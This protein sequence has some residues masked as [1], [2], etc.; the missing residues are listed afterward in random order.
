MFSSARSYLQPPLGSKCSPQ[1]V[2]IFSLLLDPNVLLSTLISYTFNLCSSLNALSAVLVIYLSL[3]PSPSLISYLLLFHLI[4]LSFRLQRS[5]ES[6]CLG[7]IRKSS[8]ANKNKTYYEKVTCSVMMRV[9]ILG[10]N[11]DF[12][13]LMLSCQVW[14]ETWYPQQRYLCEVMYYKEIILFEAPSKFRYAVSTLLCISSTVGSVI[15]PAN[16]DWLV[17]CCR[18]SQAQSF[19]FPKPWDSLPYFT[20]SWV[21]EVCKLINFF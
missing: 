10:F 14:N 18:S 16:T 9:M 6:R 1:H 13:I 19:F 3:L 17:N 20:V 8:L 21:W 11:D 7:E 2:V 5:T 12:I 4:Y 15:N